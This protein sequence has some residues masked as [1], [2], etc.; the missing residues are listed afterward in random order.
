MQQSLSGP[1]RAPHA[2][3]AADSLVIMLHGLGADGEDL[4]GLADHWARDLPHA[5]GMLEPQAA[6]TPSTRP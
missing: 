4:I 2:G 1:T 6:A 3:G 5:A